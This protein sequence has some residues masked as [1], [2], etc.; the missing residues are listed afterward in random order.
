MSLGVALAATLACERIA[1]RFGLVVAPRADRWHRRPVAL[2]GGVAIMLGVLPAL[3]WTGGLRGRLAELTL[4]ALAMGAVGLL[5]DVRPLAP[6][7]QAGG[8][9]RPRG[10]LGGARLRAAAHRRPRARRRPDRS[11]GWS[12]SRTPSTCSTTW[13]ASPPGWP[14]SRAGSGFALFLLDGDVAAATMTAGFVGAVV[15]FLVRN[16]PPAR[17]FMGD[18]GSLFLGFFLSGLCLVVDAAYYSRGI[19]AVL[20]V[21]VLLVAHPDLRHHLRDGHAAAARAS[22]SR[23][24]GATTP[25]TGWWRSAAAS[26]GR[27]RCSS[28]CRSSAAA[29]PSSRTGPTSGRPWSS[30]RCSWWG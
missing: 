23:R 21:P 9:D 1:H 16:A 17:I 29:S 14:S 26:G 27:W 5:D 28:G 22:R 13:T 8:P 4:L 19:T 10:P 20:A 24:A 2:L 15:G 18:A 12:A 7:G 6:A 25:R 30:C 11:S 3:A